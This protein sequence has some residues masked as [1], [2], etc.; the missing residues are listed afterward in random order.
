MLNPQET[1]PGTTPSRSRRRVIGRLLGVGLGV[2]LLF[3]LL[4]TLLQRK[5]I[6]HPLRET[7]DVSMVPEVADRITPVQIRG[8]EVTLHGWLVAG[9][10]LAGT[11]DAP[12]E[13]LLILY[14]PGNAAHRGWRG[15]PLAM[16]HDL[17]HDVLIVDYRGYAEN[18]GAP[19]ER[20]LNEDA[21]LVWRY[22]RDELSV[23]A[24]RIAL[25]GESLG[26]GVAVA[27]ASQL[28]DGGTPPAAL[29][30]QASFTS[31]P[32][33]AAGKFPLVPVRWLLV[34]R[35]DSLARMPRITCP[36]LILHGDRDRIVPFTHGEQL[37]AAAPERSSSGME[38][39][40][41]PLP[42]AGH[43]NLLVVAYDRMQSAIG[44]FLTEVTGQ[45]KPIGEQKR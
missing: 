2:Y 5:L 39:Q 41:V 44:A 29:I 19:S 21:Q 8:G 17:G 34:D 35:F 9:R 30:L 6:Y 33:V 7:V 4:L 27:L 18:A 22:A 45:K 42:G 10:P 31:L 28:C 12:P 40:F 24:R 1:I 3:V 36:L 11:G 15:R 20:A 32:D 25:Y 14:F 16:L 13:R 23:P 38:K 43:N 37:F 26:G